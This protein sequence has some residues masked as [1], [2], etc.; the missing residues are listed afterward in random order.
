M[1]RMAAG[2]WRF[3]VVAV[4]LGS[5]AVVAAGQSKPPSRIER[6]QAWLAASERHT[7]GNADDLAGLF[8][9]WRPED[10][11]WLSIDVNVVLGLMGDPKLETFFRM[12]EGAPPSP[13]TA[14]TRVEGRSTPIQVLYSRA[15][16]TQLRAIA[17]AAAARRGED[18]GIDPQDRFARNKNRILKRGALLHTDAAMLALSG[19]R[20]AASRPDS[21]LREITLFLPDGRQSGMGDDVGH[22]EIAS[23]LLDKVTPDPA[24][25]GMVR[26]WYI[27][28]AAFLQSQAQLSPLHFTRALHLFEHDADILFLAGCL[29]EAL[30]EPR[31]QVVM[32]RAAIPRGVTFA[33]SSARVELRQ[34]EGFFR[35]ALDANP[36]LAEARIHL[37]RVLGLRGQRAD[38]PAE[39]RRAVST[40]QDP[41]LLYY[42]E[43]FLGDEAESL[44]DRDRA[45]ASY[46]RAAA[47]YPRA[48]SP[49]LAISQL[50]KRDGNRDAARAAIDQLLTLS[51]ESAGG[52]PGNN[53]RDDPWWTYGR[54][55][56]RTANALL[57]DMRREFLN[58]DR[59]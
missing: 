30:A 9:A 59:R 13:F 33:V 6:L 54:S 2:N 34:A 48:Q 45:R 51:A 49:L 35:K 40:V 25:D 18:P 28:T 12:P 39:L 37:G 38:A 44:G 29:H 20:P 27:A 1:K 52:N 31:V 53:D 55:P 23:R 42:A 56:G 17:K 21:P 4:M 14:G 7:P 32:Q 46:N 15:E 50:A 5:C 24:R 36:D 16:L 19:A 43:L 41:L 58:E 26:S 57:A 47:L 10:F 11:E 3:V 22:W 8:D